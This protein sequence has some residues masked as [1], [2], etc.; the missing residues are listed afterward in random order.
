MMISGSEWHTISCNLFKSRHLR[1]MAL[2]RG[3]HGVTV[4]LSLQCMTVIPTKHSI[5][6]LSVYVRASQRHTAW[7]SS[8]SSHN[9]TPSNPSFINLTNPGNPLQPPTK[10][11]GTVDQRHTA[12]GSSNS[13]HNVT[14]SNPSFINLTNPGNP[15][16]P[17]TKPGNQVEELIRNHC[18]TIVALL[19]GDN[20]TEILMKMVRHR[21]VRRYRQ[22]LSTLADETVTVVDGGNMS[23]IAIDLLRILS[24]QSVVTGVHSDDDLTQILN[25]V[26]LVNTEHNDFRYNIVQHPQEDSTYTLFSYR[27]HFMEFMRNVQ[28]GNSVL[29]IYLTANANASI[30]NP[31][32]IAVLN[33]IIALELQYNYITSPE[34]PFTFAFVSIPRS[35]RT[36][37]VGHPIEQ[38][39]SKIRVDNHFSER[40]Y[41]MTLI[42]VD[43]GGGSSMIWHDIRNK[44]AIDAPFEMYFA[45]MI[46]KPR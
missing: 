46:A 13:S 7:G 20:Q 19:P 44:L 36:A 26:R 16:Q 33:H 32:T 31:H 37:S 23:V 14:P 12:W 25:D 43:S 17:P 42:I 18:R 6:H 21:C 34:L 5:R 27:S 39:L 30:S 28:A 1:T 29:G 9:V 45:P 8:N 11:N 40:K 10:R 15:L 22:L 2:Y 4:D 24:T 38:V 3:Y 35:D 41:L